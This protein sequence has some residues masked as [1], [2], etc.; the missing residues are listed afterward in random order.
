MT[1]LP[2]G[3]LC[4]YRFV[5]TTLDILL[6]EDNPGDQRL[7]RE[8]L[9]NPKSASR[10]HVISDGLE[11]LAFLRRE[12]K[13][14]SSPTP[15]I[16]LLDLNLPGKDGKEIL[17][18]IKADPSLSSIP[19]IIFSSSTNEADIQECYQLRADSFVTKPL[20]LHDF[21]EAVRGIERYWRSITLSHHP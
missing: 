15:H 21:L 8:A 2:Q 3:A 4:Y 11:A 10:L 9:N 12:G 1:V 17:R 7:V 16:I 18:E 13:F 6:I 19:V 5:A 20:E 14:S